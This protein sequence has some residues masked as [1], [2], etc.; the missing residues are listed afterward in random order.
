MYND[1]RDRRIDGQQGV[2]EERNVGGGLTTN[3]LKREDMALR[4]ARSF[5]LRY[6]FWDLNSDPGIYAKWKLKS[7][8]NRVLLRTGM[9]HD[10]VKGLNLWAG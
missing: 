1:L 8:E 2:R 4:S 6:S 5:L 10:R 3:Q 9:T 7:S